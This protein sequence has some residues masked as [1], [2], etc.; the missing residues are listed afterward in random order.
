SLTTYAGFLKGG[1]GG[2]AFKAGDPAHSLIIQ[3]ITGDPPAMP[4]NLP[5][6]TNADVEIIR[7][8]IA[9]GAKDD[10]PAV[11]D[12]IDSTHPPVYRAAPIISALAYSPDGSLLAVSGY[13]E[14]LLRSAGVNRLAGRVV[15][16]LVGHSESIES[17]AFS[18]DGSLLA[19]AGGNQAGEGEIQ[20]W[21]VVHRTLVKSIP[22]TTDTV[23]GLSFSPDG[24]KVAIGAADDSVRVYSVPDGKQLIKFDNHSDWVFGTA[25]TTDNKHLV[26]GSRDQALKLILLEGDTGSFEDDINTHH[27]P[28]RCLVRLP[29]EDKVLCAGDDG[30]VRLYQVFRTTARTMNQEDHNLLKEYDGLPA[31][32]TALAVSPDGSLVAAG[33][34]TGN[35][36]VFRVRDGRT[37]GSNR[38]Y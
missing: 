11:E 22:A 20:L 16:R 1:S 7:R 5:P 18:P 33:D 10:T 29:K 13:R 34:L 32:V 24:K 27:S 23:F 28:I 21:D 2:P 3:N 30:I 9:Q 6:L 38:I 25:F 37:I 19:V 35:L 15:A 26:S 14:T 17:V 8:W 12:N 36:R 4:K 31:P